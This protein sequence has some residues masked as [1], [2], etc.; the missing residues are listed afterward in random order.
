MKSPTQFSG[1]GMRPVLFLLLFGFLIL[2]AR[3]A[4][5]QPPTNTPPGVDHYLV[6]RVLNPPTFIVPVVLSDQFILNRTYQTY[7]LE[8][9]MTP[10]NKKNEGMIDSVTH[11][12]WWRINT[13]PFYA[14]ALISNQFAPGQQ[15][16][17]YQPQ[18]LLNPAR[19]N[20]PLGLPIP[21]K[22]HFKVYDA[23]GPTLGIPVGLEDQFGRLQALVDSTVY[24]A[25]P[26][27]KFYQGQVEPILDPVGHLAIYRILALPPVPPTPPCQVHDEFGV[28]QLELGERVLLC[29]PSY[30][31]NVTETKR[32]SWGGIK[33][34]YR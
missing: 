10:V 23:T 2:G 21:P 18:F 13:H 9:F 19:K 26:V 14:T 33:K 29:V 8:Y 25:T 27:Q 28:W 22:N 4:G 24:L 16:K 12:T 20:E 15:F 17:I 31:Y 3:A 7:T 34:K 11:Y 5:A 32:E 1:R 30:K 6:Y